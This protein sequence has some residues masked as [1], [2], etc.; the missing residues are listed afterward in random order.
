MNLRRAILAL[1]YVVLAFS[2]LF[3]LIWMLFTHPYV[4]GAMAFLVI[5]YAV[6]KELG[7]LE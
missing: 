2:S 5:W 1:A 4:I 7:Y 6:Y 3:L